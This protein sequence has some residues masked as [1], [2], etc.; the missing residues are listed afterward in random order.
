[1]SAERVISFTGEMIYWRG[2]SPFH[3][4]EVPAEQSRSIK[5][6][7]S[8]ISYGWGVLPTTLVI[9]YLSWS[10]SLFPKNGR[11]LVPIKA[12]IRKKYGLEL[13]E[14]IP[15]KLIFALNP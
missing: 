13:G 8:Q 1:M 9:N 6:F 10:T 11:Y 7:S 2:P 3:F 5:E 4:V 14:E 15:I 12:E